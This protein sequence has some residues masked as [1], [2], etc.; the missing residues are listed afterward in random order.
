MGNLSRVVE[1]SEERL[2]D[3]VVVAVNRKTAK[4]AF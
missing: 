4:V 2:F 1:T 3:C